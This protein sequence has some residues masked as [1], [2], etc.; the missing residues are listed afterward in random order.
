MQDLTLDLTQL[1]RNRRAS[2]K[3]G[4]L[5]TARQLIKVMKSRRVAVGLN[6]EL[7]L[8]EGMIEG[9]TPWPT[10][11]KELVSFVAADDRRRRLGDMHMAT[12]VLAL[13]RMGDLEAARRA[14]KVLPVKCVNEC[15]E[16]SEWRLESRRYIL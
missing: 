14:L 11:E 9:G 2:S 12:V 16:F 7:A 15:L 4:D 1:H 5:D 13:V 8:I 10:V 3:K 6:T